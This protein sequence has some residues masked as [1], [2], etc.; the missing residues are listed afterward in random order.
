MYNLKFKKQYDAVAATKLGIHILLNIFFLQ[1]VAVES[2]QKETRWFIIWFV[3]PMVGM[4]SY[5]KQNN[6]FKW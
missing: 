6:N 4:D 3:L 1:K 5:S 2:A